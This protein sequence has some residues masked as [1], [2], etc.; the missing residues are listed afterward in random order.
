MHYTPASV[1]H[2]QD[3]NHILQKYQY[4]WRKMSVSVIH[5]FG[6]MMSMSLELSEHKI[7]S[8]PRIS[9]SAY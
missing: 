9:H 8:K 1:I 7:G 5:D 2:V 3:R 6:D 4:L